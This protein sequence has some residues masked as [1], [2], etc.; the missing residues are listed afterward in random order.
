MVEIIAVSSQKGGVAKTTTAINLASSLCQYN[1]KVLVIDLDPQS[2][3]A[4]A[5]GMDPTTMRKTVF[6]V[7]MDTYEK[8]ELLIQKTKVNN[9]FIIPSNYKL[10]TIEIAL[11]NACK[12]PSNLDLKNALEKE[13]QDFD[14]VIIDCPPST[15]Y[16]TSNAL[17]FA[18]SILIP[19]Q[20]EYFAMEDLSFSLSNL[21]TTQRTINPNLDL[22]GLLITMYD[23]STRLSTEIASELF[24]T[25][26]SKVFSFPIPRSIALS[27]CQ[28]MGVPIN[29]ARPNSEAAKAYLAVARD[30][31]DFKKR[32]NS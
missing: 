8:N 29:I 27:E 19:V 13:V 22:L 2:H 3:C 6:N 31:I 7:L 28:A 30:V 5:L 32:R 20:C 1:K 16:L 18:T 24:N 25:Y 15:G 10:G 14:F 11:K 17:T 21:A 9:L 23:K 12:T 4:K 26:G